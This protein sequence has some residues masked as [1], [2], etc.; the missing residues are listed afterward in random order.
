MR[1]RKKIAISFS[2]F[3][4]IKKNNAYLTLSMILFFVLEKNYLLVPNI[5]NS[6]LNDKN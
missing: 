4:F 5:E 6:Y 3:I 1:L 2:F